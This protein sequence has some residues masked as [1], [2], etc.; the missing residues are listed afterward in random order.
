MNRKPGKDLERKEKE[1][2]AVKERPEKGQTRIEISDR[3]K[4]K[5]G[6]KTKWKKKKVKKRIGENTEEG[7]NVWGD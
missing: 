6:G 1:T 5:K 7:K 2:T 4:S 3:R